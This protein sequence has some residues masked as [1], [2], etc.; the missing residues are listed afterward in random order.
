MRSEIRLNRPNPKPL[1]EISVEYVMI[2]IQTLNINEINA[3]IF[4]AA[5]SWNILSNQF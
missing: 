4:Y 3:D 1:T 2:D 5:F